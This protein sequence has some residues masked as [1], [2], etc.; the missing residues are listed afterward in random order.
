M[1]KEI[2]LGQ[3]GLPMRYGE[4]A[5]QVCETKAFVCSVTLTVLTRRRPQS[6]QV[7]VSNDGNLVH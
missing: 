5:R 3:A 4:T 1:E 2:I 7:M 6:E